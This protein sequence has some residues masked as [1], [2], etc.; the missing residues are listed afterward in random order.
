MASALEG[1][2]I[3]IFDDDTMPGSKWFENCLRF[4][5]SERALCGTI[6]LRF[7]SDTEPKPKNL[8]WVGRVAMR[9][10]SSWI[11]LGT[12][13]FFDANGL[14]IFLNRSP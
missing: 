6:G 11:L 10:W 7:T 14:D 2:Y 8:E 4:V 9:G 5:D 12:V 3:C 1:E 13:G